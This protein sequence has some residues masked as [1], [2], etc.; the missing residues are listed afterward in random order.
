MT[1][2]TALSRDEDFRNELTQSNL[3]IDRILVLSQH[4]NKHKN[5]TQK[6]K[7]Y[8]AKEPK[9]NPFTPIIKS[10]VEYRDYIAEM[11]KDYGT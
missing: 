3:T 5:P 1:T 9:Q 8:A 10:E 6:Q 4:D 11:L 7:L 2:E